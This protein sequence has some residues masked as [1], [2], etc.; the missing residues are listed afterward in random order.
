MG[1]QKL[2]DKIAVITGGSSGIGLESAR[3]FRRHGAQ[4]VIAGRDEA[5]LEA[6]CGELGADVMT[7]AADLSTLE[8]VGVLL[9]EVESRF[10]RLDVL[11]ANAGTADC[12]PLREITEADFDRIVA[13]NV[14]GVFF[15]VVEALDLL[16]EH[17]SVVL[18]S[19]AHGRGALGDPLHAM[20]KAAVRSLARTLAADEE[21]LARGIRVNS[22]SPGSI[23]TPLT[24]SADPAVIKALD[25][26]IDTTVP[27]RRW[28]TAQEAARAALFLAGPDSAY[29]T[30]ADI[31]VDGG[32][33]QL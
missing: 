13:V 19:A 11:F 4:V 18:T 5:R 20:T 12:P 25:H 6:A 14:K 15:T 3:L 10:G 1:E 30:G 32:L 22:L 29:T 8:G 27:M 33:A 2:K 28:G 23:R 17:A 24:S 31:A 21:V 9:R 16:T 26:Y 7:V